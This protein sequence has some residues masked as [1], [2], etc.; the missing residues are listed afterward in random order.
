[1][2][3]QEQA[4]PDVGLGSR[5]AAGVLWLI[6]QRWGARIT[7]FATLVVLTHQLSPREFGVVAAAMTV[8]PLVYLLS[9]LGF[10]TYLLQADD[11]DQERLSTAFWSS[12]AAGVVLSAGL[13]AIAPLLAVAYQ[14][15]GLVPVLRV[16]VLAVTATVLGAVPAALL[17]RK[18]AFRAVAIQ[19]LVASLL[20]Q[21]VAVVIALSG[22]GVWALVFQIVVAQSVITVLAWRSARWMPSLSVSL[23]LFRRMTVFGL[24]VSSVDLVTTARLWSES[25]IITASLGTYALGLLS[26]AQRLITIALDLSAA[27][28]VPVSTVVFAKVRESVDRLRAAYLKALRVA[29]GVVSPM[30]TVVV[31]TAPVLIPLLFGEQWAGSVRATQALA[32]AGI[33]TLGAMLDHGL[34]YGLGRPG[35][36]LAYAVVVDAA[37]VA[38]TA[39]SVRWG[40]AGVAV[41][42]VFVAV[43]ATIA[44]WFRVARLLGLTPLAVARPFL[45]IVVPAAASMVLGTLLLDAMPSK[46]P[47]LVALTLTVVG[48]A[49]AIVVLLRLLAGRMIRDVLGLL[50]LPARYVVRASRLLRADMAGTP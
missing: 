41:A 22:G 48:T 11:L 15:P 38:T 20:A 28:L 3:V 45:S 32:V 46:V 7:G 40:L 17:K 34:Y 24:R 6:A 44:R 27:P 14:S 49:V 35:A 42:Y 26:I 29:Y 23:A 8:I 21:V 50:P 43:A 30:M 5:A 1:V 37:T 9:D 36:W 25:L 2:S 39:V 13:V 10:S 31:V 4:T 33:I 47:P 18:L 16:L 12:V 19:G